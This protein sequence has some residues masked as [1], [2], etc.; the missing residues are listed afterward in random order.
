MSVPPAAREYFLPKPGSYDK[1]TLQTKKLG[2]VRPTEVLV[3]VHAVSLQYRDLIVASGDYPVRVPDNLVPCSDMAGEIVDVG[4]DVK[5][6][7]VGDRVCANFATDHVYGDPTPDTQNTA[8]GGQAQGVLTEYRAFPS[9][10]LVSIPSHLSYEEASTLPCA[11]LTAYNAL[12]G[13]KPVKAGDYVLTI[14]TGGVSIFGLQFAVA[15]GAVVIATSSSD[16]KLSTASKLGAKHLIN[17]NKTADWDQ[18]VMKI[19][20]GRGVDHV[21]EVG[22]PGTL[23]KS[24]TSA[25]IGGSL[26]LIGFVARGTTDAGTLMGN[27]IRKALMLRAILVGSKAQFV[28]M[29]RLLS[30]NPDTRPMVDKVFAF[31]EA[32][33]AYAYLSSQPHVGKVVIKVSKGVPGTYA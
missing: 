31:E 19:T 17:Y 11:G 21:I 33:D 12:H 4:E 6:W 15:A 24:M 5:A 10:C 13:P 23:P 8:L 16:A 29:T 9:H 28:D 25:R 18:E 2:K 14:G 22:G 7:K 20:G 27:S 32:K 1:L 26:H 3:K 30:A